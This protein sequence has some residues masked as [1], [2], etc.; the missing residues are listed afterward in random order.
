MSVASDAV[1]NVSVLAR[2]KGGDHGK[3]P[4]EEMTGSRETLAAPLR[5]DISSALAAA[6]DD[7]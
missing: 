3:L 5:P 7:S 2:N 6:F 1:V 4:T